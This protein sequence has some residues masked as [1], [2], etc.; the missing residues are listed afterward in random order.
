MR[1]ALIGL[2]ND[3]VATQSAL[4]AGDLGTAEQM[5][6]QAR[7]EAMTAHRHTR[8]PVWWAASKLPGLG[9]DVTAVRS[10]AQVSRDLT[11]ETLPDLARAGH[12]L[13]Q[14]VQ[15][16]RKGRFDLN[17]LRGVRQPF[18]TGARDLRMAAARVNSLDTTGLV[19]PLRSP[20]EDL[21]GKLNQITDVVETSSSVLQLLPAFLGGD[22]PRRYL[23]VFQNNAEIRSLG[24][25]PG[26]LAVLGA[27]HGEIEMVRQGVN[28]DLGRYT[29]PV[30]PLRPEERTLF[31]PQLAVF[32]QDTVTDPHFPRAA[33]ILR[34]MWRRSQGEAVDGV[35]AV[36][37]VSLS[38]LLEAT[39]SVTV[40]GQQLTAGNAVAALIRDPYLR[41]T[42]EEQDRFYA[43][44]ASAVFAKIRR[45]QFDPAALLTALSTSVEERRL[46]FW[47]ARAAEQD[48]VAEHPI[49]GE[50]ASTDSP[51]PEVGV[52]LNDSASDKLTYYL[53][54][55]TDVIADRCYLGAQRLQ[56]RTVLRSRVP[57]GPLPVSVVGT[58]SPG[59]NPGDMR[60]SVYTYGPVD[61]RVDSVRVDGQEFPTN[62][63]THLDRPVGSVTVDIPRGR[64]RV[65]EYTVYSARG[66]SG[67]AEL[68]TTP[69]A[70]G[71]GV[72]TISPSAC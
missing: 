24:G 61:G 63:K 39:G 69:G 25:M 53:H 56:V 11:A 44:T 32:P 48:Q 22:E 60:I 2:R 45:G 9:D 46:L 23:A 55:R 15:E 12:K 47:S 17:V 33:E 7:D 49:A 6:K 10:V 57:A 19:E 40:E 66:Q 36:D 65:V 3:L 20:V 71:D 54:Y 8:G 13:E 41:G 64:T 4:R 62:T 42:A 27:D 1:T 18:T 5:L 35:L 68:V 43:E 30:V 16:P 14:A 52:F 38:Y 21:R 58:G 51:H 70:E 34:E 50:L 31:T 29:K 28:G 59:L 26:A 37:A 67:A 72:G